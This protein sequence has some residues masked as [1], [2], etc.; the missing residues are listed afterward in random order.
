MLAIK[1]WVVGGGV[2]GW[3]KE[4]G[5]GLLIGM[6]FISLVYVGV[7]GVVVRW[8]VFRRGVTFDAIS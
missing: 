1:G 6:Y 5:Y 7:L 8:R 2:S 3:L 4:K